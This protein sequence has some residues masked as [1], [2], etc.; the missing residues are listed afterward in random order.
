M[1]IMPD[2]VSGGGRSVGKSLMRAVTKTLTG[3]GSSDD[4]AGRG[5]HTVIPID[6][7]AQLEFYYGSGFTDVTDSCTASQDVSWIVLALAVEA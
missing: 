3:S 1:T 7:H 5:L 6:N 2:R 4:G